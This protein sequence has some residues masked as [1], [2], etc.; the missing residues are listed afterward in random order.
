LIGTHY[1]QGPTE[2]EPRVKDI[3]DFTGLNAT[4]AVER[5]IANVSHSISPH[6][7][8]DLDETKPTGGQAFLNLPFNK[9]RRSDWCYYIRYWYACQLASQNEF[10][11]LLEKLTAFWQNHFVVPQGVVFDYRMTDQYLKLLRTGAL[12]N[13][14]SLVIGV[15]KDASM[16]LFQ[17]GN[18]NT[19]GKPNENYGREL[20]ELFV[21]GQRD[22]YGNSNYTE[23]DVKAAAK[24]LTG[25]QVENYLV[26]GSTSFNVIFNP[27]R[28]DTG[29]KKFSAKYND[30]TIVGR[31]GSG[32][33]DAEIAD[34]IEMLLRNSQSAK[35]ICRKLYRWYVNPNVTDEIETN[36]IT[37]LAQFFAS[38]ENNFKIEPVVKKLL[39]SDV[40]FDDKNKGAIMKSPMELVIGM[41][42]FYNIK[43]PDINT[44]Y[45]AFRKYGKFVYDNMANLQLRLLDQ[46]SVFGYIP[47]Y[48]TGYSKN[49]ING[50]I[51][52]LRNVVTDQFI[53]E[54]P[55]Q[56]ITPGKVLIDLVAM[57]TAW[58]S[59][60]S[61][62]DSTPAISAEV[63]LDGFT[64]NL[65]ALD[66][67]Q[68]QKD[69]LID[70]VMMRGLPRR[71][72]TSEWNAYRAIPSNFNRYDVVMRRC[73]SLVR[74]MFHM[75]EFNVF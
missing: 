35:F 63:V 74:Y 34:L 1:G 20:Q 66:L 57:V 7:P 51:I 50:T 29:E 23:D 9:D 36:V 38:E 22:F 42:K 31:S 58:Q 60:F 8:I 67:F 55:D 39:T 49:W 71:N 37:P 2:E 30:T 26:E 40:F 15:T 68:S 54:F 12:G 33:G 46:P 61:D 65:F 75:A 32:A 16:L 13:F 69:F 27:D 25:W 5:L 17:N 56:Q 47:Y 73:R 64:K 59:N 43:S 52:G 18:E 53:I 11:S 62:V 3:S 21:V 4:Q 72:W 70:T 14:R 41:L 6:G 24:V 10:P 48:Q 28:H 44:D 19:K 45:V